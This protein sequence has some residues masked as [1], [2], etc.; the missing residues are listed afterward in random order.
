MGNEVLATRLLELILG[1]FVAYLV[2]R[3]GVAD[4]V[5]SALKRHAK[6]AEKTKRDDR[7]PL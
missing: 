3:A 4:G 5:A 7:P 2:I 1:I 6:L